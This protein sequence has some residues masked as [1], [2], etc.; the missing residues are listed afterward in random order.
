[1]FPWEGMNVFS[2]LK[3]KLY[4]LSHEYNLKENEMINTEK[5]TLNMLIMDGHNCTI[6]RL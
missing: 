2:I 3:R 6:F 4:L 5:F 1:M